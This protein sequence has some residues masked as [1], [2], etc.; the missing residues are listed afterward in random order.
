MS[1]V[2]QE[3][4]DLIN[5]RLEEIEALLVRIKR[6]LSTELERTPG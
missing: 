4:I 2:S 3:Q 6:I 5:R 1:T